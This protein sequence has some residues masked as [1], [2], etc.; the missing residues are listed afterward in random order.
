[1]PVQSEGLPGLW[2]AP[3]EDG[4]YKSN[5]CNVCNVLC[6]ITPDFSVPPVMGD[7]HE[8]QI[9]NTLFHG[10]DKLQLLFDLIPYL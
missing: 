9:Q 6:I 1:M 7:H 10:S 3:V 2:W 4:C 5:A 8:W